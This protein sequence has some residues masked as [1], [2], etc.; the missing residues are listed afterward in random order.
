M[1]EDGTLWC[2]AKR[3][4]GSGTAAPSSSDIINNQNVD[5]WAVTPITPQNLYVATLR[6]AGLLEDSMYDVYCFARDMSGNFLDGTPALPANTSAINAT[7]ISGI[8]TLTTLVATQFR[9]ITESGVTYYRAEPATWN[10]QLPRSVY[11]GGVERRDLESWNAPVSIQDALVMSLSGDNAN[12]C[13]RVPVAPQGGR[14]IALVRR[15]MC[16]FR[17]KA[18]G[19]YRAGYQGLIVIDHQVSPAYGSLPDMTAG[20]DDGT[21]PIPGWIMGRSDGDQLVQTISNTPPGFLKVDIADLRSKPRLGDFQSDS[22]GV[23][24]YAT[25]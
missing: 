21:M 15:G 3:D 8:R 7:K 10:A 9:V 6:V 11:V 4:A 2:V 22:F 5:A 19:I 25:F 23:R 17:K 13:L 24:V 1:S 18:T 20:S 12:G 16:K 14:W